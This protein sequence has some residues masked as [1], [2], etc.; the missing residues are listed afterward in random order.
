[1]SLVHGGPVKFLLVDDLEENLLAL[2]SLL[3]KPGLELLQARSGTQALEFLLVHEVALALIDV[4]MPE[5]DGFELA[6]L[7]RGSPRTQHVPIIFVTAGIRDQTRVFKGYDAGA[8]DFLFKPIDPHVLGNKAETFFQLHRQKQEL[9]RQ[10]ELLRESEEFRKR[11]IEGSQDC[12]CVLDRDG[13]LRS[14]ASSGG[15]FRANDADVG[16]HRSWAGLWQGEDQDAASL[17]LER[18]RRGELGRFV[19]RALSPHNGRLYWDV[20]VTPIREAG[21]SIEQL[22]VIARDATAARQSQEDLQRLTTELEST[23]RF[24]ETFVAVV[25]HDL[26]NPLNAMLMGAQ[27]LER[28]NLPTHAAQVVRQILSSGR[29]MRGIL[30][31][32]SDLARARLGSG[33]AVHREPADLGQL[34]RKVVAEYRASHPARLLDLT[35]E[36]DLVGRWDGSRVEQIFANLIGNALT[37][38]AQTSAV[39]VHID[40]NAKDTVSIS[41]HNDGHIPPDV[42]PDIFLPFRAG[43]DRMTRGQGLG[44]GLFIVEQLAT[45]HQGTV[46]VESSPSAGTTFRVRLPRLVSEA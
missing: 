23:L 44:L 34:A 18:A 4:Q 15:F 36:G 16:P 32:L 41:V 13:A 33:I 25:G 27:V 1:M 6:E 30:D 14:I 10:V 29:R 46:S 17:A 38:G 26:R 3:R 8:V 28:Q 31:D 43:R 19:G 20:A 5:M 7:M 24:N 11:M 12:I 40:G 21:G 22:L 42:L 35:T 2:E 9:S 37:H 45:A 39:V